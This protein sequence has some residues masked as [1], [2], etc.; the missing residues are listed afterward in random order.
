MALHDSSGPETGVLL[1]VQTRPPLPTGTASWPGAACISLQCQAPWSRKI[2][3]LKPPVFKTD[4]HL[5]EKAYWAREQTQIWSQICWSKAQMGLGHVE[6]KCSLIFSIPHYQSHL[7]FDLYLLWGG[8]MIWIKDEEQRL[9][10]HD[11]ITVTDLWNHG[12]RSQCSPREYVW[13]RVNMW[14]PLWLVTWE[15]PSRWHSR[16]SDEDDLRLS[17]SQYRKIIPFYP[18]SILFWNNQINSSSII[19]KM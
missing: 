19:E 13:T 16:S 7:L 17:K 2:G 1:C 12:G 11:S 4:S 18:K 8:G 9:G 6:W 3:A 14:S 15:Q 10:K 5:H